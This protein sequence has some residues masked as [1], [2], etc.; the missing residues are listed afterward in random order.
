MR[1][2]IAKLAGVAL[3]SIAAGLISGVALQALIGWL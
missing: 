3:V 1:T 2:T